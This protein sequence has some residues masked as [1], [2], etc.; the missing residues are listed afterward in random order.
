M[1]DLKLGGGED[2]DRTILKELVWKYEFK[3][4]IGRLEDERLLLDYTK[5][6]LK[7]IAKK[8]K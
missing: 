5:W 2:L 6:L 1:K 3:A 8:T 4:K 7:Q